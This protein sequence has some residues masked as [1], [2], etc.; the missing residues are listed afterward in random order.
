MSLE[1][2]KSSI[3]LQAI[4]DAY[5]YDPYSEDY[6]FAEKINLNIDWK[7]LMPAIN[8]ALEETAKIFDSVDLESLEHSVDE[9]F[10]EGIIDRVSIGEG[11]V[12]QV[13]KVAWKD[14]K[15]PPFL[16]L[17]ILNKQ[18]ARVSEFCV[19]KSLK[20]WDI[21]HRKT[22]EPYRQQG[23]GGKLIALTQSFVQSYGEHTK[24]SQICHMEA[25]QLDILDYFMK[26]GYKITPEKEK[27]F[28]DTIEA[29]KS[30]DP[31]LIL[32]APN[33]NQRGK[34]AQRTT[35]WYVFK[36]KDWGKR[37]LWRWQDYRRKSVR[38]PLIKQIPYEATGEE[39]AN[40]RQTVNN[41]ITSNR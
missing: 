7:T 32:G 21:D 29:L 37:G 28:Y 18:G 24:T 27:E 10:M 6:V 15:D 33:K 35:A 5:R 30:G 23:I 16:K 39:V 40:R 19:K 36:A 34:E 31:Q 9:G 41:L 20:Y 3:D 13:S 38:F 26:R 8:T 17:L 14:P 12:F 4:A 25:S 2:P 11:L 22:E 1:N